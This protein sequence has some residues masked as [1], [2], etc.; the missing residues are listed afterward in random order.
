L[1]EKFQAL[2]ELIGK[3]NVSDVSGFLDIQGKER[4]FSLVSQDRTGLSMPD[5]DVWHFCHLLATN[6]TMESS[7]NSSSV[8][9][10]RRWIMCK[11]SIALEKLGLP[12][13]LCAFVNSDA[14][15][16]SM[17]ILKVFIIDDMF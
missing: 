14:S 10:L 2:E 16:L 13:G 11:M 5:P 3:L 7:L 9:A 4:T 12:V 8:M 6:R 1:G 17:E 15:I